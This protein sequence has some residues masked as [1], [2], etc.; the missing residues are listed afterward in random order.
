MFEVGLNRFTADLLLRAEVY[1][2]ATTI[3]SDI[4]TRFPLGD[5]WLEVD[6]CDIQTGKIVTKELK[7]LAVVSI[8]LPETE[9]STEI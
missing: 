4:S 5:L 8:E 9:I 2:N 3:A 1:L 6:F 7:A